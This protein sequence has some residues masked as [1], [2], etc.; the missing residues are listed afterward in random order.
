M[1]IAAVLPKTDKSERNLAFTVLSV[2]L[3]ST[4]AMIAY[5]LLASWFHFDALESGV[6]LGGTIH[7]VA[8]V[9]GAGFSIIPEV[10][11]TATLVKLIRVSMLAPVVLIFSLS[12]R[13]FSASSSLRVFICSD[14]RRHDQKRIWRRIG[15]RIQ[16]SQPVRLIAQQR[17]P[18]IPAQCQL[19]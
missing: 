17:R 12:R 18:V 11:E 10:G 14:E 4:V 8:Q 3:L 19:R 2:T 13:S 9:V 16:G 7:D 6:F 1:A 15:S 5:P